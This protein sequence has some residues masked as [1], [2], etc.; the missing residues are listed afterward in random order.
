VTDTSKCERRFVS[1]IFRKQSLLTKFLVRVYHEVE[2]VRSEGPVII[3]HLNS[4]TPPQVP[5]VS[6]Y[7][8][9]GINLCN[10]L[11]FKYT[12]SKTVQIFG[13]EGASYV[14]YDAEYEKIGELV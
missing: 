5:S 13:R 2:V 7:N 1:L 3:A 12:C 11:V 6:H 14:T 8:L 9:L 10:I 4:G